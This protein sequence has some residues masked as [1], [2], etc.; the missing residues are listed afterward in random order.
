M[1]IAWLDV[2]FM[3]DYVVEPTSSSSLLAESAK[4]PLSIEFHPSSSLVDRTRVLHEH[5]PF[6]LHH[7]LPSPFGNLVAEGVG[8]HPS[9]RPEGYTV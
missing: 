5:V 3:V 7:A 1:A 6:E 8:C 2:F 9:C 4:F